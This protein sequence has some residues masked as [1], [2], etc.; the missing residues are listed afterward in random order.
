MVHIYLQPA[1]FLFLHLCFP[2]LAFHACCTF[3]RCIMRTMLSWFSR[4]THWHYRLS[5]SFPCL[6]SHFSHCRTTRFPAHLPTTHLHLLHYCTLPSPL[7]RSPD[8][9]GEVGGRKMVKAAGV[10]AAGGRLTGRKDRGLTFAAVISL[11]FRLFAPRVVRSRRIAAL[12]HAHGFARASRL[13]SRW[14][15][16]CAPHSPRMPF[17]AFSFSAARA[18][19]YQRGQPSNKSWRK[20]TAASLV[21]GVANDCRK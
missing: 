4:H 16:L 3:P 11:A 13:S 8:G 9:C 7:S 20:R 15:F 1:P 18:R 12:Y 14:I 19:V 10:T 6:C 17:S 5:S 21:C 2:L